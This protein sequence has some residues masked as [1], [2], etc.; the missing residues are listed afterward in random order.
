L[1]IINGKG[2]FLISYFNTINDYNKYFQLW[3]K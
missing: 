2:S 1:G 3:I